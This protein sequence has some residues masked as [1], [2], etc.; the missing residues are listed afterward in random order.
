MRSIEP[1][2][3]RHIERWPVALPAAA[4]ASRSSLE[5]PAEASFGMR[6]EFSPAPTNGP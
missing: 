6:D 5:R 3:R 2:D 4:T 1:A